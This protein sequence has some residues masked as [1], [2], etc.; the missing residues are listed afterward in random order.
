[1]TAT[2]LGDRFGR[3]R[4]FA[5]GLALFGIASAACAL[6][7][8]VGWLIAARAV[9]GAGAATT[10]PLALA[11][12]SGAFPPER[13]GWAAGIYGSV[14]GLAALL[15]PVVGGAVTEGISWEWIV[16]LN[17]RI[18]LVA[19]P[20]VLTRIEEVR[21]VAERLDVPGLALVSAA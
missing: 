9:Q 12:M 5:L 20:L 17:V 19:I 2:A 18:A 7:P 14:A 4:G 21:G 1:M 11:L 10:M 8:D 3:R 15:G 6:A 16:W 13:R